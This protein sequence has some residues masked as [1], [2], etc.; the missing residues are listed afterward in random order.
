MERP[1]ASAGK[2]AKQSVRK[3]VFGADVAA[4]APGGCGIQESDVF[5]ERDFPCDAGLLDILLYFTVVRPVVRLSSMAD[6]SA[7]GI[8]RRPI[9][10]VGVG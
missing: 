7:W 10:G 2:W 6:R 9:A 3:I 5:A 4:G 1:T 8:S